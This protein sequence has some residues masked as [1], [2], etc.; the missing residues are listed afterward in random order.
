M[1]NLQ[2]P[3]DIVDFMRKHPDVFAEFRQSRIYKLFEPQIFEGLEFIDLGG[4]KC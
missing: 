4:S 3:R 2:S 1:I